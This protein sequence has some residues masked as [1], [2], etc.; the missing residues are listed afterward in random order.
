MKSLVSF[1]ILLVSLSLSSQTYTHTGG[2]KIKRVPNA[3]NTDNLLGISSSGLIVNT[4]IE[5]QNIGNSSSNNFIYEDDIITTTTIFDGTQKGLNNVFVFNSE[6][7]QTVQINSG[8]YVENDVINIERRGSGTL[9]IIQ[10]SGVRI[11]G[12]RDINNRYFVNDPNSIISL[13]CRGNNEFTIIGNLKRGYTGQVNVT[14]YSSFIDNGST[15][16]ITVLGSGFSS[17]M[18]ITITGNSVLNSFTFVNN[19]EITL[20]ISETGSE[21]DNITVNYDNGTYF[22][23][24]NAITI[25][26]DLGYDT[27]DLRHYY[28]LEDDSNDFSSSLNGVN[29]NIIFT[30]SEA[31]FNGTDSY[32]DIPD[33]NSLSYGNSSVD[34]DMSVSFMINFDVIQGDEWLINKYESGT[35]GEYRFSLVSVSEMRNQWRDIPDSNSLSYGNSSVDE[36]MSVSFMINFDVIQGDEWLIN[37]YESGTIG[38]YRFSL[39]SVSEMRNQWRDTSVGATLTRNSDISSL[40]I[41]TWYHFVITKTGVNTKLYI[42]GIEV[43]IINADTGSY[44]ATENNN[45]P[46]RLGSA[47]WQV[48]NLLDG[49]MKRLGFWNKVLSQA[50]ITS[51]VQREL[52]NDLNSL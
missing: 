52:T 16:N 50:E 14:S 42:D 22:S 26:P 48:S 27:A 9:E 19:N 23:D 36:D 17:N 38:E 47:S 4:G 2:L 41:N 13:L 10:G 18:L 32:I 3:S 12:I 45:S 15:Q 8:D 11:R 5:I 1:L 34:E 20:N 43:A 28:R 7:N 21:G 25:Q 39:V 6:N 29:T 40:N 44:V 49:K 37:K 31:D 33:S 30:G 24:V 51:L 46:V 35:I